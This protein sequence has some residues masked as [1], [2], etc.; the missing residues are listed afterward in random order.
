MEM[1][2]IFDPSAKKFENGGKPGTKTKRLQRLLEEA[3]K[4]RQRLAELKSQG[5]EGL[6]RAK[7]ELW[8]DALKEAAGE[9]VYQSTTEIRKV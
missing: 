9:K 8:V 2:T 3:E 1:P 6:N 4:K 5:K 7:E